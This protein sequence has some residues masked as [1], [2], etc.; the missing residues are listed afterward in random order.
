M[1]SLIVVFLVNRKERGYE[2]IVMTQIIIWKDRSNNLNCDCSVS[3]F[4]VKAFLLESS[5]LPVLHDII[6][7]FYGRCLYVLNLSIFGDE[8]LI[9]ENEKINI[10]FEL[11][12][13]IFTSRKR[14]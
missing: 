11:H 6:T 9:H 10:F 4:T 2:F 5:Q 13:T 7:T 14:K 3:L 1:F 8:L 12:G